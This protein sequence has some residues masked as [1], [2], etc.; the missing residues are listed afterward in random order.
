MS[1][2][3]QLKLD[4]A[5]YKAMQKAVKALADRWP[6]NIRRVARRFC[7]RVMTDSKENYCPVAKG[8]MKSTGH[9]DE[10]PKKLRWMLIYG[11]PAAMYTIDQHENQSYH[12]EVGEN[13]FLEKPMN[14]A[15]P[16]F[17][18]EI[19]AKCKPELS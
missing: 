5:S 18:P 14:K 10:D 16:N 11:G 3:L 12:H 7:E 19:A 13:K 8:T 6:R 4:Q 1:D 15:L 2:V 9:V 17:L